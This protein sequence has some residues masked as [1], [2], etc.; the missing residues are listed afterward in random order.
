MLYHVFLFLGMKILGAFFERFI[1]GGAGRLTF[2][3]LV[4]NESSAGLLTPM[5]CDFWGS[6]FTSLLTEALF[7]GSLVVEDG[8]LG[9]T[10]LSSLGLNK[11]GKD[12]GI[13]SEIDFGDLGPCLLF[14]VEIGLMK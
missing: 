13:S 8:L 10:S 2:S 3:C 1:G 9:C 11:S 5:T 4:D 6:L 7:V 14:D 12:W